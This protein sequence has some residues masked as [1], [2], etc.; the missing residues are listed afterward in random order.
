[1][2]ALVRLAIDPQNVACVKTFP[3][4]VPVEDGDP[5]RK[6]CPP[7]RRRLCT[8]VAIVMERAA[9]SL[10]TMAKTG[11]LSVTELCD[12][13]TR[14]LYGLFLFQFFHV[15]H[16]DIKVANVL[17]VPRDSE[18]ALVFA[19]FG[20]AT[21]N[22]VGPVSA[23]E[24]YKY[25]PPEKFLAVGPRAD[26]LAAFKAAIQREYA[27]VFTDDG[28]SGLPRLLVEFIQSREPTSASFYEYINLQ[29]YGNKGDVWMFG[30]ALVEALVIM[31]SA[32][33]IRSRTQKAHAATLADFALSLLEP[34]NARPTAAIAA[35]QWLR[36]WPKPSER[37]AAFRAV[38]MVE[39]RLVP[40]A[41]D[42]VPSFHLGV[43]A[44]MVDLHPG[45]ADAVAA[46]C[47]AHAKY[48]TAQ[49]LVNVRFIGDEEAGDHERL[50]GFE[51]AGPTWMELE[52]ADLLVRALFT[53]PL[54]PHDGERVS[55]LAGRI[56][57][58][59][60]DGTISLN[61]RITL[62]SEPLQLI[63]ERVAA[64]APAVPA[65]T[66]V[67]REPGPSRHAVA[68]ETV[69][70]R[71]T[72]D[73]LFQLLESAITPSSEEISAPAPAP[74]TKK[75][76]QEDTTGAEHAPV[77]PGTLRRPRKRMAVNGSKATEPDHAGGIRHPRPLSRSL[78]SRSRS[79]KRRPHTKGLSRPRR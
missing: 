7:L 29:S 47:A 28:G 5:R 18:N 34:A 54:S 9:G 50:F 72:Y 75:R 56:V 45:D 78:R 24:K 17:Q 32:G 12:S 60:A 13:T 74:P 37:D 55:H 70:P 21:W 10:D 51:V 31:A 79:R 27:R 43:L 40:P 49:T 1:M 41:R 35:R 68:R 52:S 44:D 67:W 33:S 48:L 62:K 76:A 59:R 3:P 65:R 53:A 66:A 64:P 36:L 16:N 46:H 57:L 4:A 38:N 2:S 23:F 30:L 19:D 77:R 14:L 11:K 25:F 63:A 26:P 71:L 69:A 20:M 61:V 22:V 8:P 6:T 39:Q 42:G 73:E 15:A 58:G